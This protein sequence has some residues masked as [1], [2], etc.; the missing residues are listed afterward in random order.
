MIE[1]K[2]GIIHLLTIFSLLA[3]ASCGGGDSNSAVVAEKK[4]PVTAINPS[5]INFIPHLSFREKISLIFPENWNKQDSN[6][7]GTPEVIAAFSESPEGPSDRFLENILLT[8]IDSMTDEMGT[9]VSNIKEISTKQVEIAGFLGEESIFDA[10]VAGVEQL[11]LRFMEIVFE[12]DGSNYSLFYSAE[13]DVFERNTKIVRHMAS[14]LNIGQ[15]VFDNLDKTDN[16]SNPGKPAVVSDGSGFLVVSC[17]ESEV[18]PYPSELIGRIVNDDR[19]M[20]SEFQ[21]HASEGL[22]STNCSSTRYDAIF[23]GVNYL[24]TYITKLDGNERIVGKRITLTGNIVD[25]SPID[26]SKNSSTSVR[27]YVPDLVFDGNRTLVVWS[28]SGTTKSLKGAFVEQD[29]GVT[30]SFLIV[31]NVTDMFLNANY[32][33][34]SP[35]VAYGDN[36]FMV[37]WSPYFFE[38]TRRDNGTPIFGQV[39]NLNGDTLLPEPIQI[40][41]DSGDNPRYPQIASDGTN[42]LIGWIEGLLETNTIRAGSFKV[43]ARQVNSAGELVGSIASDTGI[44]ISDSV[45]VADNLS[46]E[47]PKGF[48]DLSYDDG[49]YL[50]LWASANHDPATGV[51][52]A[53][54]SRN[55]GSISKTAPITGLKRD[56]FS[57]NFYRPSQ[58]IRSN[59]D[60]KNFT[61]WPSENGELEGWFIKE[62]HFE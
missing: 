11:D 32:T 17:R 37:I 43:Y 3:L 40:K 29:G 28:E 47:V 44:K 21:I 13:R 27:V 60:T 5:T 62:D 4:T 45:L 33:L 31:D 49:S 20:S 14:S 25:N 30:D 2:Q 53:K 22:D 19:T 48:L 16:F 1:F 50:F 12:F 39:L 18:W 15:V 36:Q 38:N 34:I 24:V 7:F 23:D 54:V 52:G 35:H 41:S 8:K 9:G 56:T 46:K 51:Y 26:I 55:L 59:S 42:Y 57:G 10:D 58:P 61:L 6:A